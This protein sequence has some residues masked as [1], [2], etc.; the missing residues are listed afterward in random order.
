MQTN[1][2]NEL[3]S[4]TAISSDDSFAGFV[5][6][7]EGEDEIVNQRMIQGTRIKFS[8]EGKWTDNQGIELDPGKHY[9]AIGV[10]RVVNKWPVEQGPPLETIVLAPGQPFPNIDKMN[11]A[12]PKSEW[13]E[14]FG[15]Q[16]GPYKPQRLLYLLDRL[17]TLD[18]YTFPTSTVGGTRAVHELAD[19]IAW[20]RRY[21][22]AALMNC[23][24]ISCVGAA[25][26]PVAAITSTRLVAGETK[27]SPDRPCESSPSHS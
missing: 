6:T 13:R 15:K 1:D 12:C 8:N 14:A 21:R 5:D 25:G 23:G 19:K 27:I 22:Q 26:P 17:M 2:K 9:L 20:M 24:H 4:T 18:K 10:E 7:Y 16:V 11:K 3:L